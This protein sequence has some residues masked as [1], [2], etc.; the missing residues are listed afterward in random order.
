MR[1][2]LGDEVENVVTMPRE[3]V[4]AFYC[5]AC[6]ATYSTKC[7]KCGTRHC[8]N[9]LCEFHEC[10]ECECRALA[11]ERSNDKV[12]GGGTPSA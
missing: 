2:L 5:C 7:K 4:P 12:S 3:P 10:E 8:G 9:T 11:K 6:A 1:D